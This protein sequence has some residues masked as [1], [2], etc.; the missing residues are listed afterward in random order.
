M[1]LGQIIEDIRI[2]LSD[3]A[4]PYLHSTE[5]LISYINE[6]ESEACRRGKI[7]PD[8]T[9]DDICK[10]DVTSGTS[11]YNLDPRIIAIERVYNA[12][13]KKVIVPKKF[14]IADREDC[15]WQSRE[16]SI[17]NYIV[18]MDKRD[19]LRLYRIPTEDQTII[20]TVFREPLNEMINPDDEPEIDSTYHKFLIHWVL[21]RCFSERDVDANDDKLAS[22]NLAAFES[23]F[24]KEKTANA[25]EEEFNAR[26]SRYFNDGMY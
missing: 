12:T 7:L 11:I 13:K 14:S 22:I 9:T 24:G 18:G 26:N 19:K 15:G 8:S 17:M 2:R 23:Q 21:Y 10:I 16:G 5:K 20:L 4:E 25:L 3:T 1:K 6:A